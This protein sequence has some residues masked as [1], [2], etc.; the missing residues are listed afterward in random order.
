MI[1][2]KNNKILVVAAHPDDEVLGCGGTVNRLAQEGSE[3][4]L[5]VMGEG[6]TARYQN[7]KECDSQ[8]ISKLHKTSKEISKIQGYQDAF[9]FSLPDNRF[10]TIPLLEIIK[11]IELM[12]DQ[13]KPD[14]IFTHHYG[15]LNIDH[16]ITLKAVLT[17]TRPLEDCSVK[18]VLT[19][20]I[21][22]STEWNFNSS[23]NSV[24]QPNIFVDIYKTIEHKIKALELYTSE[25]KIFPHPRSPEAIKS[26]SKK[27]GS[28]VGLLSAEPFQ[29]I[30]SVL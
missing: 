22:S 1:L 17:A 19:F 27:W 14:T 13:I 11:K 28:T 12:I 24:F 18:N 7:R 15:D 21:P 10:D 20:E 23:S 2:S 6:V 5:C 30:R 26:I 4:Y 3:I 25:V 29:L 8:T 9:F 16:C